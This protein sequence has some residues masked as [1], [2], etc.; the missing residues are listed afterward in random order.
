MKIIDDGYKNLK[1]KQT[2]FKIFIINLQLQS[3]A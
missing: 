3:T 2:M 1:K